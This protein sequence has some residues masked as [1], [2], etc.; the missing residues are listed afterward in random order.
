MNGPKFSPAVSN[1]RQL[2]PITKHHSF[3]PLLLFDDE[4]IFHCIISSF[5]VNLMICLGICEGSFYHYG[6]SYPMQKRFHIIATYL[7]T[8]CTAITTEIWQVSYNCVTK[9]V[10]LFQQEA[11]FN[12]NVVIVKENCFSNLFEIFNSKVLNVALIVWEWSIGVKPQ[13]EHLNSIKWAR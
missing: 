5:Q 1:Y 6:H 4:V 7:A 3:S 9:Y 13:T 12:L 11:T 8:K 2:C 10:E